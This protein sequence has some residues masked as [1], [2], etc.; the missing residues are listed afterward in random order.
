MNLEVKK[1]FTETGVVFKI[2]G[3]VTTDNAYLLEK[4]LI[5]LATQKQFVI[6][7]CTDLE[8]M[9]SAGLRCLLQYQKLAGNTKLKLT[10]VDGVFKELLEVTGFIEIF[11]VVME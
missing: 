2:K 10:H 6:I 3:R 5:N 9:S 11:T 1:I 4:D 7:D 8:Y